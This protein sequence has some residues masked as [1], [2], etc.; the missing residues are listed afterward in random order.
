MPT[1]WPGMAPPIVA[2][3]PPPPAIAPSGSFS[4]LQTLT[5]PPAGSA[6]QMVVE[7][8]Q[9]SPESILN[10]DLVFAGMSGLQ[11]EDGLQFCLLGNTNTSLVKTDLSGSD[12]TLQYAPGQYGLSTVTLGA[13]DAD[14][15]SM[16]ESIQVMVIP[17]DTMN[18]GTLPPPT[19]T[20]VP[21]LSGT[22]V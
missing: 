20:M 3:A 18:R 6:N 21:P 2:P 12:L 1:V 11:H 17:L 22:L 10:M 5:V 14:G 9:N 16:R 19:G 15:V 4:N 13:T 7:V 8:M